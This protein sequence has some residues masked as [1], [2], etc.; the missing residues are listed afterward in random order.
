MA[1]M[2]RYWTAHSRI[3]RRMNNNSSEDDN[4]DLQLF[5]RHAN[6]SCLDESV[7][8]VKAY[9]CATKLNNEFVS[10]LTDTIMYSDR[11]ATVEK[12]IYSHFKDDSSS[13]MKIF[14]ASKPLLRRPLG[15][16]RELAS[17]IIASIAKVICNSHDDTSTIERWHSLVENVVE[18]L[19]MAS[20][21]S[22]M[23]VR[24]FALKGLSSIPSPQSHGKCISKLHS[25]YSQ[26]IAALSKA[27]DDESDDV[28]VTSLEGIRDIFERFAFV[29]KKSQDTADSRSSIDQMDGD[30][31][32]N[33]SHEEIERI[34]IYQISPLTSAMRVRTCFKSLNGR[35]R[36]TALDVFSTIFDSMATCISTNAIDSTESSMMT[37]DYSRNDGWNEL[38]HDSLTNI[39][40]LLNDSCGNVRCGAKRC[41]R[42]C[43]SFLDCLSSMSR[44]SQFLKLVSGPGFDQDK[45]LQYEPFLK[46]LSDIIRIDY[47]TNTD[48]YLK[49]T[50][51]EC[52]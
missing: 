50:M 24:G 49:H 1:V 12:M 9:A 3:S 17:C 27:C 33:D 19:I 41:I 10:N 45:K 23:F 48:V 42:T 14:D 40:F 16:Y 28:L 6:S 39:I 29:E 13:V 38:I 7:Q 30:N 26:I 18:S 36:A 35:V 8:L 32:H 51:N 4:E 11:D 21:D 34:N 52:R 31:H 25:I 43:A 15:V 46:D 44:Q 5:G 37:S 22:D 2:T 47:C 20:A